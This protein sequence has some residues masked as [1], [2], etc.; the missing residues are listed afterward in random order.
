MSAKIEIGYLRGQLRAQLTPVWDDW[1]A[2]PAEQ[3]HRLPAVGKWSAAQHLAH[4]A[5]YHQVFR[6]RLQQILREPSPAFGRYRA[7]EDA[8]WPAWQYKPFGEVVRL[9]QEERNLL[10]DQVNALPPDALARTGVHPAYG[11]LTVPQWLQFFILHE[12][13]HLFTIFTLLHG[14]A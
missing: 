1:A 4:L 8:E 5:R 6:G 2:L 9:L 13:H 10:I 11:T 7:E 12:G 14:H 3:W